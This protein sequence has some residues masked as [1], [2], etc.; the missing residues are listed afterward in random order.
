MEFSYR[1]VHI[2]MENTEQNVCMHIHTHTPKHTIWLKVKVLLPYLKN[3]LKIHL[4]SCFD[5]ILLLALYHR[6]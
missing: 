3:K 4:V 2:L 6:Q 1:P 5:N